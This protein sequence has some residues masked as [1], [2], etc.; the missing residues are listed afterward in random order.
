MVMKY[1][2]QNLD[3]IGQINSLNRNHKIAAIVLTHAHR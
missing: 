1:S 2:V 3:Q